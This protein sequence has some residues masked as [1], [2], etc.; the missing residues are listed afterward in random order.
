MWVRFPPSA[1]IL[2]MF[3]RA[4]R[5]QPRPSQTNHHR[6]ITGLAEA[7]PRKAS[8]R[9]NDER[10]SRQCWGCSQ[11]TQIHDG[12]ARREHDNEQHAWPNPIRAGGAW[13]G[14]SL[15][16]PSR[17]TR[18]GDEAAMTAEFTSFYR[19]A[20]ESNSKVYEFLCLFKIAEGI[21]RRGRGASPEG[22]SGFRTLSERTLSK[23][24]GVG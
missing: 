2:S 18:I 11:A 6:S 5:F 4:G 20:L 15:L 10:G 7:G 23:S 14:A 24:A 9:Q 19:E 3:Y 22:A 13:Q 17:R 1:P 16:E 21:N 12:R 8:G